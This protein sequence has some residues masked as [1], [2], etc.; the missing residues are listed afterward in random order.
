MKINISSIE[1]EHRRLFNS[2]DIVVSNSFLHH[3][4]NPTDLWKAIKYMSKP[5]AIQLH[6]DLRRP[7][8]MDEVF[9]LQRIYLPDSPQ[10]LIDDYLASLQAAFTVGEVRAQLEREGLDH[11]NVYESGD[12]YLEVVGIF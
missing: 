11:L 4:H 7:S 1:Q 8:S 2:A 5:G 6:R 10:V 3:L 12:R 9:A